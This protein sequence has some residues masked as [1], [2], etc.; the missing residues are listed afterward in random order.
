MTTTQTNELSSR[1][2]LRLWPGVAIAI[3]QLLIMFGGPIVAP[4]A[5]MP[6]GMFGGIVGALAIV[7]WWVIFSRARWVERV[8]AVILMIVAVLATRQVVHE[9][10]AGAGQGMLIYILPIPY[11][12]LALVA[13]AAA[14]RYLQD[15]A[16]RT[17]LVA[18]IVLAMAP[19]ALIRTSGIK[20][21]AGS[22]FHW[23]WTP[24]PEQRLLA[25]AGEAP[26]PARDRPKTLPPP[27]AVETPKEPLDAARGGPVAV[28]PADKPAPVAAGPATATKEPAAPAATE[29]P[30]EWPG[31]R[32][33]NRDDIIHGVRIAT[34]WSASPP[35]E[36]WRR[37]IGPGWSSFAVHGD[38]IYTQEQR[39]EEEIVASYKLSN[40]EP[41]WKHRDAVRF[42][43][44]NG[45]PGPRAT[46]TLSNGRVYTFGAT[47]ILNALDERNG[48]VLWSHNVATETKTKTTTPAWGFSASPLVVDDVVIVAASGTLAAYDLVTGHLRW[49]NPSRGGSYSSPHLATIDGVRQVLLLAGPGVMSVAPADGALLWEHKWDGGAIVQPAVTADGD[50]VI[51]AISMM[52]GVGTRRLAIAHGPGGWSA[53]ERWTSNGL[54]PYFNDFVV[55]KGHAFGF[56]GSILACIDLADGKRKWKGG[57]F[58]NGQLVLL[59][60]QDV[61]LVLSEDGELA[62]VSAT[63]DKFTELARFPVFNAK[64]WNHPVLIG[65]VLLIRNGEEMAA[66]RLTLAG[67]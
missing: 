3:A 31:F 32:G 36:L 23:R 56:D 47:G 20:G 13:W 58:G 1:K 57:R 41:L 38:R 40:G 67:S 50:V 15:G 27:A 44:S 34:D 21:G 17:L 52:G 43:E 25:Q 2:P 42:Y 46:P 16:R 66:F 6:V 26:D 51:N 28:K 53:E 63:A 62:L 29:T 49:A 10:I 65:D 61:L 30:V 5:E 9:S 14:T 22:E 18:A 35:V 39:G 55:H 11:L 12:S 19:F 60:D 48:A 4:D 45:G 37:P 33:P 54:K 24:T 7:V 8:G 64:T 59:P